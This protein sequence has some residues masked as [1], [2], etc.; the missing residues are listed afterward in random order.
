[1]KV[2]FLLAITVAA[3]C[4][5][6]MAEDDR[7]KRD[8]AKEMRRA[9]DAAAYVS[10]NERFLEKFKWAKED[11]PDHYRKLVEKKQEAEKAW[12][13]AARR[14]QRAKNHDQFNACK[15]PAY[16]AGA[17]AYL[18]EMELKAEASEKRWLSSA[19]KLGTEIARKASR[20]LIENQRQAYEATK[21]K[22]IYENQLREL[23]WQRSELEDLL[24]GESRKMREAEEAKRRK[25]KSDRA[26]NKKLEE[27]E[28]RPTV[29]PKIRIE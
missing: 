8:R 5:P 13:D 4:L 16:Q 25:P 27:K 19:E 17:M 14:M 10:V 12:K 3:L 18:A 21:Q 9:E 7:I 11:Y 1:M 23:A 6:A 28:V 15:I 24:E 26:T 2:P 20:S 22:M 29:P